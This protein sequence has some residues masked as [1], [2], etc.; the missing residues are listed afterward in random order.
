MRK[1]QCHYRYSILLMIFATGCIE[2]YAPPVVDAEVNY[3]VVD[4]S[5]DSSSG[6][7]Q[8]KL[9]RAVSLSSAKPPSPELNSKVSVEGNDGSRYPLAEIGDGVYQQSGLAIANTSEYRLH[10]K[11]SSNSEYVSDYIR[12][13]TTPPIDEVKWASNPRN[14]G[15]DILIS[16]H[17]DTK[18]SRYYSW[19]YEETYENEAPYFN[20][21]IVQQGS[22]LPTAV[23]KGQET[24]LCWKTL[25][26]TKI[27]ITS[28]D[29]LTDD[30]V[31]NFPLALIPIGS[32]KVI[33][34]YSILVKQ[35]VLNKQAYAYWL[36]LQ[37][38]TET[39]GGLFDPQPGRVAGN[40]HNINDPN[41]PA[42]GY[43]DV[44]STQQK[45]IFIDSK[46]I[47]ANLKSFKSY[48]GCPVDTVKLEDLSKF[49]YVGNSLI[50]R[51]PKAPG[52]GTYGYKYTFSSCTTCQGVTSKPPFW[53]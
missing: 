38:T 20:L 49:D 37:K 45:R 39:L 4:G 42:I 33:I 15:I 6:S 25:P 17:D 14:D 24:Y 48:D 1:F 22:E 51:I 9:S 8:V 43:F 16:S 47:P 46:E 18:N 19:S 10:I 28:T 29:K 44:G 32:P 27:S 40:I 31:S 52:P 2:A 3:L 21:G 41:I 53:E 11:T 35:R 23:P 30:V 50:E 36:A 13:K 5:L 34:K 7:A 12:I 26:S